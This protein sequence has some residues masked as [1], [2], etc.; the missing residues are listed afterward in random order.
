MIYQIKK[1][2]GFELSEWP[3]LNWD[4]T[5][6][7]EL[8]DVTSGSPIL[9]KAK[10]KIL[11]SEKYLY[12]LFDVEDDHIWG[13]YQ[14]ND[15]PIYEQE[16]VEAF[17]SFGEAIPK[18]YLELQFSPMGI[19]FDGKVSNPTGSRHDSGFNVDINWNSDLEFKQRISSTGDF[20]EYKS[21]R[22][23]TQVK[24]PVDELSVSELKEGDRLRGNL[25]RIDGYPQ[26]NSFQALVPNMEQTPNFHT[27]KHFAIFELIVDI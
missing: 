7:Y 27:P 12:F 9:K 15:D 10:A 18:N 22:W 14:N 20:G 13:T 2:E 24:L 4:K 23:I 19:K 1:T 17:I 6:F 3:S 11:W 8:K 5:S 25:F 16:V 26:Q 21:G